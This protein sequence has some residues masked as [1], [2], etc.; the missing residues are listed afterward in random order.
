MEPITEQLK[1]L[2]RITA[3]TG[4]KKELAALLSARQ[5]LLARHPAFRDSLPLWHRLFTTPA[6]ALLV[7]LIIA[8]GSGSGA[9]VAA[10]GTLPGDI[11]YPVKRVAEKARISFTAGTVEKA[12]LHVE[13]ATLRAEEAVQ[14]IERNPENAPAAATALAES[15]K[16]LTQSQAVFEE[17][18][19][20]PSPEVAKTVER[21]VLERREAVRQIS[22]KVKEKNGNNKLIRSVLAEEEKESDDDGDEKNEKRAWWWRNDSRVQTMAT[23][24]TPVLKPTVTSTDEQRRAHNE[25]Q[26]RE[27]RDDRDARE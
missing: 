13:L 26:A 4:K 2:S 5:A 20:E 10:Q 3:D 19:Q 18:P 22:E 8:L 27:A 1:K 9:V 14:L 6:T 23:S 17:K 11:L 7:A 12:A 25:R 15:Q 21:R 16:E 24:T